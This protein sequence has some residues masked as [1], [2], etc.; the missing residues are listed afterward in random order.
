MFKWKEQE[1]REP[2]QFLKESEKPPLSC[3]SQARFL[4]RQHAHLSHKWNT[5][6]SQG[7]LACHEQRSG[8]K[9]FSFTCHWAQE[10]KGCAFSFQFSS[11]LTEGPD[12]YSFPILSS[13]GE[14]VSAWRHGGWEEKT[15]R[16]VVE[17]RNLILQQI[18]SWSTHLQPTGFLQEQEKP[19]LST[20]PF[21]ALNM[22]KITFC[23]Q[24]IVLQVTVR[25][26]LLGL[27]FNSPKLR[28]SA[29]LHCLFCSSKQRHMLFPSHS[30]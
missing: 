7:L 25:W 23:Q 4:K 11:E 13:E 9:V 1:L 29:D 8:E 30:R 12:S 5:E 20:S 21:W 15:P 28:S 17:A 26:V 3:F 2:S 14:T 10:G 6:G 22:G 19:S 24:K 27:P 16:A 18:W